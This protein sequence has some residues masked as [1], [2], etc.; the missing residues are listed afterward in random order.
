[1]TEF[2]SQQMEA[3]C[4]AAEEYDASD[5]LLHEGCPPLLRISGRL[6]TLDFAPPDRAFFEALWTTCGAANDIQDYDASLT[7]RGGVRFRVNLL[8]QLGKHAA[9]LRRIRS[10]IPTL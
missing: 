6:T 9:V 5:L 3:L 7:S 1:M 10:D 2:L 4:L 8:R